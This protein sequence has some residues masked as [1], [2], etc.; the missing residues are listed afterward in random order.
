MPSIGEFGAKMKDEKFLDDLANRRLRIPL[1]AGVQ[2]DLVLTIQEENN[3]VVWEVTER[4]VKRVLRLHEATAASTAD[5]LSG[6]K[7]SKA[8]DD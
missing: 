4:S 8:N 1:Q 7:K 3:G 6:L 2:M 5:L